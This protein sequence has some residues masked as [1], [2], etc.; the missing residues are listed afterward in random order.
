MD[1]PEYAHA[2]RGA[3]FTFDAYR[4]VKDITA[5][6]EEGVASFPDFDHA[7]GDPEENKI[8]FDS[9]KHQVVIV[10]GL[11]VLLDKEPWG[12]L[13][14]VFNRTFFLDTKDELL[15]QRHKVRMTT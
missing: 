15:I 9:S 10:E 13:K 11:Y 3:E 12:Q 5:A 14:D 1:D 7:M 2:R 8:N 6:K 4:F